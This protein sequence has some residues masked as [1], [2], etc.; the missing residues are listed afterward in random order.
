MVKNMK[1][2]Y[3]IEHSK[4]SFSSIKDVEI[5]FCSEIQEQSNCQ[6]DFVTSP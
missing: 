2:L 6:K 1:V 4:D 3:D 5:T